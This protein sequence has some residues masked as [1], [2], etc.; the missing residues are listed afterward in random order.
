MIDA[1]I[2]KKIGLAEGEPLTRESLDVYRLAALRRTLALAKSNSRYYSRVLAGIDPLHDIGSL[3]DIAKL[4]LM[5]EADL[6]EQGTALACVPASGISR[7]V[8]LPTSGTTGEPKRVYFTEADQELMI[9]YIANG[10]KVMTESGG[11]WLILMPVERPGSVGDLVRIGLERIGCEV[12]ALG[13]LP[14]DGSGDGDAIALMER[15]GVNSILATASAAA[16][17]AAKSAGGAVDGAA[18]ETASAS[19]AVSASMRTVLLSAEYVSESA[20]EFIEDSWGCE[21]Y[22]H[23]GMTEMGLGGAMACEARVGYH[24]R[25]ADLIFEIID[26]DTGEPLPD[27]EWGEVVFTTLTREAMPFIRYRTG[28]R[29]R[30]IKEPC[31]CGSILQRLD[32]VCDRRAV[33]GY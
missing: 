6:V 29:S 31:P 25:E 30:F 19:S 11:V 21:V 8:T 23:Y 20:K 18:G 24:P 4:P 12:I 32:R 26:P 2:G 10:L 14:F 13:I 16:R 27:G 3:A 22:E 9:D 1:W 7:I 33:K 15:R 28:D 17:L 5:S